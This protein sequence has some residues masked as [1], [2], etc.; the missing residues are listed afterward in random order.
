MTLEHKY[1]HF[2][3]DVRPALKSKREEFAVLGYDAVTEQELWAYLLKKKWKKPKEDVHLYE[4]V[5]DILSIQPGH[6]MNFATVE[7]FKHG[8]I[9]LD[10]EAERKALLK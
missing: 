8:S 3:N 7:A 2:M 10:N 6:Y 1:E 9:D 5:A 4:I